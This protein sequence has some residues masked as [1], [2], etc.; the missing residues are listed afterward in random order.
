MVDRLET[1]VLY[2][3]EWEGYLGFMITLERAFVDHFRFLNREAFLFL[4]APIV[5]VVFIFV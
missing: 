4:L 3:Y 5:S 1:S 2:P